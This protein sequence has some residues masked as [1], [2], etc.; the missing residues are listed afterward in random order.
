MFWKKRSFPQSKTKG[1]PPHVLRALEAAD[2]PDSWETLDEG[3]LGLVAFLKFTRYGNSPAIADQPVIR[4]LYS[5]LLKRMSEE[6]RL[7]LEQSICQYAI[8]GETG[9]LAILPFLLGETAL[10]VLSTASLDYAMLMP[11]E[12]G[13][14]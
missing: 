4:R 7:H 2:Q 3:A 6:R 10:S 1:V 8:E 5:V 12:K 14:T 13:D 11:R 9:V